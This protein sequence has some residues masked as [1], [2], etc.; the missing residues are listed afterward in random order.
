MQPE[1]LDNWFSYHAPT[2]DQVTTYQKLRDGAR[3]F[4]GLINDLVPESADKTYAIRLLRMSVMTG[5]A[6]IACG[7]K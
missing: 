3:V 1:Q 6:A 5:N 4:A 2:G 7:G